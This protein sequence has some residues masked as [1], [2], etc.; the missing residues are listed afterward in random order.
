[1]SKQALDGKRLNAFAMNPFSL[2]IVG[3]DTEDT[4][5]L[6]ATVAHAHWDRRIFLPLD[7]DMINNILDIGVKKNVTVKKFI[8]KAGT[9]VFGKKLDEDTALPVITDGRQRTRCARAGTEKLREEAGRDAF[10]AV[11]VMLEN[12]TDEA[13]SLFGSYALNHYHQAE[14]PYDKAV[15][16]K[17]LL[18]LTQDREMV[19]RRLQWGEQ[20]LDEMLTL[21]ANGAPEVKKAVQAG[22]IGAS[23]AVRLAQNLPADEQVKELEHAKATGNTSISA[24]EKRIREKKRQ[25]KGK[26]A[27]KGNKPERTIKNATFGEEFDQ[28]F[29]KKGS[30]PEPGRRQ[31]IALLNELERMDEEDNRADRLELDA[32]SWCFRWLV[33][34]AMPPKCIVDAIHNI[35]TRTQAAAP[36]AGETSAPGQPRKAKGKAK[37]TKATAVRASKKPDKAKKKRRSMATA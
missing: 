34:G 3:I 23:A 35:R 9:K 37:T 17:K 2:V 22:E 1:M 12:G 29:D 6:Q 30:L 24:V 33:R 27:A 10:I 20:R 13:S 32:I 31:M 5:E 4:P 19:C 25:G 7:D 15:R 28:K 21:L 8:F 11:P 14:T 16:A 36:D 18:D 26:G